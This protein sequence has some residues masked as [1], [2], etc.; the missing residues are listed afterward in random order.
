MIF[1]FYKN[2]EL[3]FLD[4]KLNVLY[5]KKTSLCTHTVIWW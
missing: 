3:I 5:A 2:T 4:K 1:F